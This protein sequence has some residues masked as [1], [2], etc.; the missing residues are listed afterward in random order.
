MRRFAAPPE[1]RR[2]FVIDSG[3]TA[4]SMRATGF[5]MAVLALTEGRARGEDH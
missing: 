4:R 2:R 3:V 1:S 5:W